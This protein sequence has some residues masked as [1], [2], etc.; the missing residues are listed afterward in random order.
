MKRRGWKRLLPATPRDWVG[1]A[2]YLAFAALLVFFVS[3]WVDPGAERPK[4]PARENAAPAPEVTP[5]SQAAGWR[6]LIERH[7]AAVPR[8]DE[9]PC[10]TFEEA[11]RDEDRTPQ[12]S[13]TRRRLFLLVLSDF[14]QQAGCLV[15][16][17]ANLAERG[18][19]TAAARYANLVIPCLGRGAAPLALP[20]RLDQVERLTRLLLARLDPGVGT[21]G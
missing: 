18:D 9:I 3:R 20:A 12:A 11:W 14:S 1:S 5:Q 13:A 16:P 15:D 21:S 10:Q 6:A 4:E 2:L 17:P 19:W 8:C 7:E